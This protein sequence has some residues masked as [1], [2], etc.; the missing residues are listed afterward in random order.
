M[1]YL[2]YL[3]RAS[4]TFKASSFPETKRKKNLLFKRIGSVTWVKNHPS[5]VFWR[6]SSASTQLLA[7]VTLAKGRGPTSTVEIG[8]FP[9]SGLSSLDMFVHLL[10][11][12]IHI[13]VFRP[14]LVTA[15]HSQGCGSETCTRERP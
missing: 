10:P 9:G 12:Y 1:L 4:G 7:M 5:S 11:G 8:L 3:P 2:L 13:A 6:K 15:R 14:G